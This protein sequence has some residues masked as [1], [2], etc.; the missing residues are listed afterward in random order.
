MNVFA[1]VVIFILQTSQS[2]GSLFNFGFLFWYMS[3]NISLMHYVKILYC[4]TYICAS[5]S[6]FMVN[7]IQYMQYKQLNNLQQ[8]NKIYNDRTSLKRK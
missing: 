3:I 1:T 2:E 7:R 6:I 4:I 8:F 5:S